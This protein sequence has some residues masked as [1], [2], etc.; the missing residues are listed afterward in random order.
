MNVY[1]DVVAV[2]IAV[3]AITHVSNAYGDVPVAV[4]IIDAVLDILNGNVYVS[5]ALPSIVYETEPDPSCA[6]VIVNMSAVA[7]KYAFAVIFVVSED[8]ADADVPETSPVQC[9]NSLPDVGIAVNDMAA[10]SG[11]N[12]DAV[13]VTVAL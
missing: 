10:F 3:P 2:D 9:E 1:G 11:A 5:E 6:A 12:P 8:D 4:N 13:L 7:A